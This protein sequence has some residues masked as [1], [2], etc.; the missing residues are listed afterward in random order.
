MT[1]SSS[2]PIV[3]TTAL[4]PE[5][6]IRSSIVIIINIIIIMVVVIV[7]VPV[8]VPSREGPPEFHVLQHRGEELVVAAELFDRRGR[9]MGMVGRRRV[10]WWRCGLSCCWRFGLGG[11]RMR[12]VIAS[13]GGIVLVFVVSSG[14]VA[15]TAPVC[16][17][18]VGDGVAG[19]DALFVVIVIIIRR[20][21]GVVPV[22][23]GGLRVDDD[24]VVVVRIGVDT[25]VRVVATI[26][27][28]G[29]GWMAEVR[30]FL[31]R[32]SVPCAVSRTLSRI[33]WSEDAIG[34]DS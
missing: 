24:D 9:G 12:I 13:T 18:D 22:V 7:V 23:A 29:M 16:A 10:V 14:K 5:I 1:S 31:T 34:L 28:C 4:G 26:W 20:G 11:R 25:A 21:G 3:A 17:G 15:L 8:G 30:V 2:M 6:H 32:R 33:M 27:T 19:V